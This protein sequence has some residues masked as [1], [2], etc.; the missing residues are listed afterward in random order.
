MP[1]KDYPIKVSTGDHHSCMLTLGGRVKCWGRNDDG[2]TGIFN[3][4]DDIGDDPGEIKSKP[5]LYNHSVIDIASGSS[6]S[7]AI[8]KETTENRVDCW[9]RNGTN[10]L[11]LGHTNNI[12]DEF[13]EF[14]N[15]M[16]NKTPSYDH[17]TFGDPISIHSRY[18]T[19]CVITDTKRLVCWGQN[20]KGD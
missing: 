1:E 9:G 19:T 16:V 5:F 7:C 3:D 17:A 4:G 2:V 10:Q 18:Y 15:P 6:H 11:G 13:S 12:G 14:F 8:I 20:N